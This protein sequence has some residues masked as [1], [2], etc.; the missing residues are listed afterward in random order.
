M[1]LSMHAELLDCDDSGTQ[2]PVSKPETRFPLFESRWGAHAWNGNPL[3]Y[4]DDNTDMRHP[5]GDF[6]QGYWYG[7]HY[8]LISPSE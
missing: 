6:L 2:E 3:N 7:R 8:K 1:R 5:G 4:T